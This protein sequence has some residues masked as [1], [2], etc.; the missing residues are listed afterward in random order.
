MNYY[1]ASFL[2]RTIFGQGNLM[3]TETQ[4]MFDRSFE[5]KADVKAAVEKTPEQL[6]AEQKAAEKE[7]KLKAWPKL[8]TDPKK[9]NT[10]AISFGAMKGEVGQILASGELVATAVKAKER[11]NAARN[12][13]V[14]PKNM[15]QLADDEAATNKA[16]LA[17]VDSLMIS[18]WEVFAGIV[19]KFCDGVG[20]PGTMGLEKTFDWFLTYGIPETTDDGRTLEVLQ[21]WV[22]TVDAACDVDRNVWQVAREEYFLY[23]LVK[24]A[25]SLTVISDMFLPIVWLR[26]VQQQALQFDRNMNFAAE[27]CQLFANDVDLRC[28]LGT[29]RAYLMYG[30]RNDILS[31]SATRKTFDWLANATQN[32]LKTRK[33]DSASPLTVIEILVRSK[34]GAKVKEACDRIKS[35]TDAAYGINIVT[36]LDDSNKQRDSS[37]NVTAAMKLAAMRPPEDF[38]EQLNRATWTKCSEAIADNL[39]FMAECQLQEIQQM[40]QYYKV[41]ARIHGYVNPPDATLFVEKFCAFVSDTMMQITSAASI[42]IEESDE[43]KRNDERKAALEAKRLQKEMAPG[44]HYASEQSSATASAA[45]AVATSHAAVEPSAPSSSSDAPGPRLAL[46]PVKIRVRES[47]DPSTLQSLNQK[48]EDQKRIDLAAQNLVIQKQRESVI[49]NVRDVEEFLKES[50][51][52]FSE[53]TFPRSTMNILTKLKQDLQDGFPPGK[54]RKIK[55]DELE[56]FVNKAAS[57]V[58][59]KFQL[60]QAIGLKDGTVNTLATLRHRLQDDGVFRKEVAVDLKDVCQE[61]TSRLS[62]AERLIGEQGEYIKARDVLNEISMFL[63]PKLVEAKDK[64]RR[65]AEE[66]RK[67]TLA[68]NKQREYLINVRTV[69]RYNL[70]KNLPT[71][72]GYNE[73]EDE[74]RKIE[75]TDER[76]EAARAAVRAKRLA[77]NSKRQAAEQKAR[78]AQDP[79]KVRK[80]GLAVG[81]A[82]RQAASSS[83][84]SSSDSDDDAPVAASVTDEEEEEYEFTDEQ[85]NIDDVEEYVPSVPYHQLPQQVVGDAPV[86]SEMQRAAAEREKQDRAERRRKMNQSGFASLFATMKASQDPGEVPSAEPGPSDRPPLR[87]TREPPPGVPRAPGVPP[88]VTPPGAPSLVPP[89]FNPDAAPPPP[90]PFPPP[91]ASASSSGRFIGGSENTVRQHFI[92]TARRVRTS[93]EARKKRGRM[94]PSSIGVALYAIEEEVGDHE[95]AIC[96]RLHNTISGAIEAFYSDDPDGL[97]QLVDGVPPETPTVLDAVVYMLSKE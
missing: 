38:P 92:N 86:T 60:T 53:Y 47:A 28:I 89:P 74:A 15:R 48:Q 91:S 7:A 43:K 1:A 22:K 90:P 84:S 4:D 20:P 80:A 36:L 76:F 62:D 44:A 35:V 46:R 49:A 56:S 5:L 96:D 40:D 97:Q 37:A 25:G 70:Q 64:S 33:K 9:A 55:D 32:A 30:D 2:D 59:L 3:N 11:A 14:P 51:R 29:L 75:I 87:R 34:G 88:V 27:A 50:A 73:D 65:S 19:K 58:G 78:D 18:P 6:E 95:E 93:M 94:K 77:D 54:A 71:E 72:E 41:A 10:F 16:V 67:K 23:L 66:A 17:N 24:G 45:R 68:L 57:L 79:V 81:R 85:L 12:M 83:S 8:F 39:T 63:I 69:N 52:E 26:Q 42:A 82:M 13:R 61:I 31:V 21:T